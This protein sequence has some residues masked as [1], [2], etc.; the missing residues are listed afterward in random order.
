MSRAATL[1][2]ICSSSWD[3]ANIA[4][5]S[6]FQLTPVHLGVRSPAD[7]DTGETNL[8]LVLENSGNSQGPNRDIRRPART[9]PH[10]T[11]VLD[12]V[13]RRPP[14][15]FHPHRATARSDWLVRSTITAASHISWLYRPGSDSRRQPTFTCERGSQPR[16]V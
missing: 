10:R 1:A 14:H 15:N 8:I 3:S 11:T 9:R 4:V 16:H 5:I 13:D 12:G 7:I 2:M 6:L